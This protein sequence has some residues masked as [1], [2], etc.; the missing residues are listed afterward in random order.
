MADRFLEIF[1]L[2]RSSFLI[3]LQTAE[4]KPAT[5]VKRGLL[6]MSRRAT[7]RNKPVHVLEF[8]AELQNPEIYPVDLV[9]YGS[10]TDVVQEISKL[11]EHAQQTFAVK[12]VFS[13]SRFI[14]GWIGQLKFFKRNAT[15]TF[16]LEFSKTFKAAVFP[17]IP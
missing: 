15:K 3:A 11:W 16:F 17:S 10:T 5:P 14:G 12:P 8:S 9:K 4:C 6:E 1:C 13:N 2:A 7:F